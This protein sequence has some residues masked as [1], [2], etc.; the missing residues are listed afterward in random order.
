MDYHQKI[1][2]CFMGEF[3]FLSNFY[4]AKVEFEGITYP[5][6]EHAYQS[7]KTLD[8]S[9]RKQIAVLFTP[10]RAKNAGRGLTIR[11]DWDQI[12]L[13]VMEQCVR[14][15]FTHHA[16]L[17]NKLLSTGNALIEEGNDWE[18]YFWGICDGR[19]ENHL[20]K[21]LIKIRSELRSKLSP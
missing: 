1:V 13:E 2:S 14:Y 12:K 9:I 20:G 7:A 5:S 3:Y 6:V 21:I 17:G 19:G 8:I 18:D 15:K 4:P 11:N 10:L 16:F